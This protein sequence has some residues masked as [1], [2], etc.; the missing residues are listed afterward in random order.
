MLVGWILTFIVMLVSEGQVYYEVIRMFFYIYSVIA[1][2]TAGLGFIVISIMLIVI[3]FINL[4]EGK[5]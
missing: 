1:G 4:F 3:T 2:L 5:R